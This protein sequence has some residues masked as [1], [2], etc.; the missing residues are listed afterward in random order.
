MLATTLT[1]AGVG[2]WLGG[3][4][5]MTARN[6]RL[7]RFEK[8]IEGG[9]LLLMVDVPRARVDEIQTIVAEASPDVHFE[10]IEATIPAFP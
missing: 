10:G 9:Q 4:V 3:M 6:T 5:G 2:A 1:G 8:A 7:E